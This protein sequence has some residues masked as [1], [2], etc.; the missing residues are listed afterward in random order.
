M[1]AGSGKDL[2]RASNP[3]ELDFTGGCEQPYMGAR[4]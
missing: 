1:S 2:M 3:L 4:N